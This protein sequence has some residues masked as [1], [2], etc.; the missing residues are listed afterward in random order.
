[1]R[2]NKNNE[3]YIRKTLIIIAVLIAGF[4]TGT[5]AFGFIYFG[6]DND[7]N[8]PSPAAIDE[9]VT[10]VKLDNRV[11]FLLIG[12]DSRPGEGIANTDTIMVASV[13]PDTK[14]IS[15]LSIPRDTRVELRGSR[16]LKI[17]SMVMYGGIPELMS[18]V[19]KVTGISLDGYVMTNLDGFKNIVDTL[20]GITTY[21]EKDMYYE[22]GDKVDGFID[23][24]Q[25]EQRLSGSQALQYA[26]FRN[27]SLADIG[28]TARQQN[29]LKA[30]AKEMMQVSTLTKLPKLV[31]QMMDAIE[32]DLS[33]ADILKLSRAAVAFDSSNV[34]SQTLPG[35]FLDFDDI[36]YW[37]VNLN[38]VQRV[39]QNLLLGIT[40]D[41]VVNN[42]VIDLLDPDIRSHITVPANKR[43][44]NGVRSPGHVPDGIPID[45]DHATSETQ[46]EGSSDFEDES[47]DDPDEDNE[48]EISN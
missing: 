43:D 7:P 27:D 8:T 1:M 10:P 22:T 25:G 12:T 34:I 13:D 2:N 37:E 4:I 38:Q 44:P 33:V 19:T 48:S 15:I 41:R 26:R 29:L 35:V 47:M 40:T 3:K 32:T 45:N 39:V 9:E 30:V 31:P 16:F 46:E 21:V 23:L 24:K 28:R 11:S 6:E 42:K 18:Q 14:I 17:N 20:G 5:A 36:S